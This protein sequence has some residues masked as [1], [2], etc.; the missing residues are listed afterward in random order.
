MTT[1]FIVIVLLSGARRAA[2]YPR[3]PPAI[4]IDLTRYA[5]RPATN[6]RL[7]MNITCQIAIRMDEQVIDLAVPHPEGGLD[8]EARL[9][10]LEL[11]AM[12]V[13]IGHAE[14]YHGSPDGPIL[15]DGV[16]HAP[17]CVPVQVCSACDV[18][19]VVASDPAFTFLI[20]DHQPGCPRYAEL[21][22]RLAS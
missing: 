6:E 12:P 8:P 21:A 11:P 14:D 15:T 1:S 19:V 5:I 20:A 18:E 13:V 2:G 17:G 9:W 4:V 16:M 7:E 10:R 22:E 3:Q